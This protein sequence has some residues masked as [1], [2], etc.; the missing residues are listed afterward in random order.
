M[1]SNSLARVV[2]YMKRGVVE[3]IEI[4]ALKEVGLAVGVVEGRVDFGEG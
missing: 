1:H 2:T 3:L 4:F